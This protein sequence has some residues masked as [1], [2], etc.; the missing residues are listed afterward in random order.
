MTDFQF[1]KRIIID[2]IFKFFLMFMSAIILVPLFLIL[3]FLVSKGISSISWDFFVKMPVAMGDIG[4][5]IA[6]AIVGTGILILT[7]SIMA[8]PIGILV[9]IFLAEYKDTRLSYWVR[10]CC[11]ILQGTPSIVIGIVAWSW[12]VKPMGIFSAFSG[13]VALALMMLPIIIRS[14][15][16]T[17]KLIPIHLKEA[18]LSLG[19]P[20]SKT[21]IKVILPTGLSSII[22]GI[23][24]SVSRIA[25]ETAPLIF[26]AFGNPFM[27]TRLF[28]PIESMP[29]LI[30]RYASSPFPN[31]HNIAWGTSFILVVF[32]LSLNL[33]SK[34]VSKRWKIKY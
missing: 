34:G 9:G 7:A 17:I 29:L 5:G 8:I 28:R 22:S 31:L 18:S 25:G 6:N 3:Y 13:G 1:K 23:L 2:K 32:I 14:V 16:E 26:T 30:F 33:I 12:I 4:G 11:E 24:L 20:Y 19:V 15:E 21:I 27:S 10:I